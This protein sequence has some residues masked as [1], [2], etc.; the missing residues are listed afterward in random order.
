MSSP[1]ILKKYLQHPPYEILYHHDWQDVVDRIAE[2]LSDVAR[3]IFSENT[4]PKRDRIFR[5]LSEPLNDKTVCVMGIDPYPRDATGVPFQ[6]PSFSKLAV[7]NLA[8][9]IAGHYG[10]RNYTNFDFS[11]IPGVFPWNYYLSCRV[12]ETKSQAL[13][14]ERCSK[15][16][17]NH[18]CSRVRLLYCLGR[19]DFENVKSKIENPITLVV[20]YHPS[21]RDPAL[22][23]EDN[24]LWIVNELLALQDLEPVEWWRGLTFD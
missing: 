21:T 9:K 23:R 24:S 6:S 19:S 3:Y 17:L 2:P 15:L 8:N 20:G 11:R 12:G 10:Y 16:L 13:Y 4:S 5:Q 1:M 7:R 18:I 22:F 14:W